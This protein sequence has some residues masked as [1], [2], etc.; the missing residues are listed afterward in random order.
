MHTIWYQTFG[1]PKHVPV[2][3]IMGGCCQGVLWHHEFCERLANEG[4]FVIRYDHRDMGLSSC[5]DFDKDPYTVMDMA[6]DALWVLDAVGAKQAILFGVSLGGF[7][8][9]ILAAYFP[10]RVQSLLLLG[11]SCE[12]RPMNLAFAGKPSK[13][14]FSPPT[15]EYL[16]W[17]KEFMKLAATSDEEKLAQRIEGWRRLN[18]NKIPLDPR[19]NREMHMEFLA[20]MRYPQGIVNH[21][22]MLNTPQS[23]QLIREVPAQIARPT[24][25]LQ[26]TEDPIFPPDHGKA[27]SR[28][29]KNSKFHLIEGMGHVPNDH[30]YEFY[31]ECIKGIAP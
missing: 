22:R 23:E 2:L 3:L 7:L 30:F 5:Y 28:K 19:R 11:S 29:I 13:E 14:T 8:A 15:Q 12:I 31:I 9:E 1:N 18:G 16:E 25:V 21:V 27:L 6:K 4:Y 24:I 10:E 20:R 26:G 17:M